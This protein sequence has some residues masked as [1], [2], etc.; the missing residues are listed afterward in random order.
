MSSSMS[1]RECFHI[2]GLPLE[3]SSEDIKQA[4]RTKAK[5]C[6]PDKNPDD[7]EATARFQKISQAYQILQKDF[8]ESSSFNDDSDS[9]DGAGFS[10]FDFLLIF[11]REMMRE[12]LRR[13]EAMRRRDVFYNM[14]FGPFVSPHMRRFDD[15]DDDF[16]FDYEFRQRYRSSDNRERYSERAQPA[17]NRGTTGGRYQQTRPQVH[18]PSG[19]R[20]RRDRPQSASAASYTPQRPRYQSQETS[21]RGRSDHKP[22][23]DWGQTG[24]ASRDTPRKDGGNPGKRND[25]SSRAFK[26]DQEKQGTRPKS[27]SRPDRSAAESDTAAADGE[28][29]KCSSGFVS[30]SEKG[31]PIRQKPKKAP[32]FVIQKKTMTKKQLIAQQSRRQKEANEIGKELRAKAEANL[33]LREELKT[34]TK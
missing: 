31:Q 24:A 20:Q 14:V 26:S 5:D 22:G 21:S 27:E 1:R 10:F 30:S 16:L 6:H 23:S 3:S 7:P 29:E 4:Y 8:R 15:D 33:K 13:R 25:F 28:G 11:Q 12:E 17:S 9:D 2:L 19:G 18:T 32:A 34:K